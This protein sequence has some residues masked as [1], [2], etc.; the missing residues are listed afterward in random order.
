MTKKIFVTGAVREF[1]STNP[2]PFID[3]IVDFLTT[4]IIN[5]ADKNIC[6]ITAVEANPNR[7]EINFNFTTGDR[8]EHG[9]ISRQLYRCFFGESSAFIPQYNYGFTL[10][11]GPSY[12]MNVRFQIGEVKKL[13]RK[14]NKF[15]NADPYKSLDLIE[16][17]TGLS[18]AINY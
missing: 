14:N 2:K 1:D 5:P 17:P 4:N 15:Y 13:Y 3:G 6:N 8:I 11:F 12:Q 10:S 7:V 9:T 16:T 18:I